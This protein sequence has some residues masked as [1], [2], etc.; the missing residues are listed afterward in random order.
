MMLEVQEHIETAKQ[1]R[2]LSI[3]SCPYAL[4]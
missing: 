4:T 2:A 3:W 1:G